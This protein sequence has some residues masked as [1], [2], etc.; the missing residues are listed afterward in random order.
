MTRRLAVVL[1]VCAVVIAGGVVIGARSVASGR[2]PVK[3]P[4]ELPAPKRAQLEGVA[5]AAAVNAYSIQHHYRMRLRPVHCAKDPRSYACSFWQTPRKV[6]RFAR[7]TDRDGK[8]TILLAGLVPATFCK[9]G[10]GVG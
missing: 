5:F 6:C 3:H 10:T 7:F 9:P 4:G 1:A 2:S 8:I